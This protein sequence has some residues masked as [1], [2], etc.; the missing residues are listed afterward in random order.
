[1]FARSDFW[2]GL[3]VGTLAGAFGYK[4]MSEQAQRN[5]SAM[6]MQP[7]VPTVSQGLSIEEL[8]RQKEQLEDLIAEQ[9]SKA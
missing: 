2:I 7:A 9:Q 8:I 3:V 4:I 1:M 5:Q 6:A